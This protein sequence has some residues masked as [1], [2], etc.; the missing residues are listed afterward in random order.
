MEITKEEAEVILE[1]I[2]EYILNGG[3]TLNDK[4]KPLFEKILNNFPEFKED[5]EI[6]LI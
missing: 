4:R 3:F 2:R 5:Y 6:Y 1:T